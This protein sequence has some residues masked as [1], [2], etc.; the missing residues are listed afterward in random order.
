MQVRVGTHYFQGSELLSGQ[1]ALSV[2]SNQGMCSMYFVLIC[3]AVTL[4]I[5]LPRTLDNLTWMGL[6]SAAL[7]TL[8]GIVAM[9]GAG[10]NPVLGRVISATIPSN[11][12]DAFL[13]I[14]NPVSVLRTRK[15]CSKPDHGLCRYSH[16]LVRNTFYAYTRNI[17]HHTGHFMY[18]H[19]MLNDCASNF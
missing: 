6:L 9:V 19:C 14:T 13:A 11:F 5:S 8:S 16:M 12:Y 3:G 17:N 1:Q 2:L 15:A 10:M 7:I 4:L 18:A